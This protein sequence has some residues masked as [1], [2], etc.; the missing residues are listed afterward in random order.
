[1]THI[2]SPYPQDRSALTDVSKLARSGFPCRLAVLI[3]GFD[4]D[5]W[6]M[7][8][9]ISA[10]EHL[11]S[12]AAPLSQEVSAPFDGLVHPVH[13]RGRVFAWEVGASTGA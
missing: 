6:S 5:G 12:A 13:K 1:V 8:P 10:F 11:A 2:L 9:A 3:Y 4:Y 7:D